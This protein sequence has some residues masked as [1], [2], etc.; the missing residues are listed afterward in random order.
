L[1][2][3]LEI[4]LTHQGSAPGVGYRR[5]DALAAVEAYLRAADIPTVGAA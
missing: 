1:F 5:L 4:R 3:E 2:A